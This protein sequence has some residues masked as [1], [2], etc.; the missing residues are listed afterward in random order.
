MENNGD[1]GYESIFHDDGNRYFA[2]AKGIIDWEGK[3]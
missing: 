2:V 1:L 3:V